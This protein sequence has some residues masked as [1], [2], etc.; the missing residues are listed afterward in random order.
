VSDENNKGEVALKISLV[1]RNIVVCLVFD[2]PA[3]AF[4]CRWKKWKTFRSL[5]LSCLS[6]L[7]PGDECQ[8]GSGQ[9]SGSSRIFSGYMAR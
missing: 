5:I 4:P 7:V 3:V 1:I 2:R 9:V 6:F 8:L